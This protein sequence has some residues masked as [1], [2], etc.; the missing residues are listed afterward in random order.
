MDHP[1]AAILSIPDFSDEAEVFGE[2]EAWNERGLTIWNG[3]LDMKG[4]DGRLGGL[5]CFACSLL[6]CLGERGGASSQE[7]AAAPETAVAGEATGPS[8]SNHHTV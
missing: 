5:F 8:S 4:K 2:T 3:N 6:C 1:K 7:L